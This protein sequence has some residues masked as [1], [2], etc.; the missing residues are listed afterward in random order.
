MEPRSHRQCGAQEVCVI[1]ATG[2]AQVV[3]KQDMLLKTQ[4]ATLEHRTQHSD[5]G[6]SISCILKSYH[7]GAS[8][9]ALTLRPACTPGRAAAAPGSRSARSACGAPAGKRVVTR[10]GEQSAAKEDAKRWLTACHIPTHQG[11]D[12][13]QA[14]SCC[15][16]QTWYYSHPGRKRVAFTVRATCLQVPLLQRRP[17]AVP[18]Y[19]IQLGKHGLVC[20]AGQS[21]K[22][23]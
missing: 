1:R 11:A 10:Q 17:G 12:I 4:E 9:A 19:N 5:A 15:S 21:G 3:G 2:C 16:G 8:A 23:Y 18:A 13:D 7:S 22:L 6:R 14:F 20:G